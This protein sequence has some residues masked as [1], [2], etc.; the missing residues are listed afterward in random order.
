MKIF[1]KNGNNPETIQLR[2]VPLL[3]QAY[4]AASVIVNALVIT[5]FTIFD[6]I[7][8]FLFI[9]SYSLLSVF[10][11]SSLHHDD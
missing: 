4:S 10:Q 5:F 2:K 7:D 1:S 11:L 6:I 3:T 8:F 9:Y